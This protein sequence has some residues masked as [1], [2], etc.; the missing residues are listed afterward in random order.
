[1]GAQTNI[2]TLIFC[3]SSSKIKGKKNLIKAS[4]SLSLEIIVA[5]STFKKPFKPIGSPQ[6]TSV[7]LLGFAEDI[8]TKS[9]KKKRKGQRKI[10]S[11]FEFFFKY[12]QIYTS[13]DK[14]IGLT[15]HLYNL[16]IKLY[17]MTMYI[18]YSWPLKMNSYT[19]FSPQNS[20]K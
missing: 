15:N 8:P 7:F 11:L 10:E 13:K 3:S 19:K 12:T 20:L 4:N 16:N 5:F 2:L 1:M 17:I 6:W 18:S 9:L 14:H